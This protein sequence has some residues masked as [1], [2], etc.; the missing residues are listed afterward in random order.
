MR[1]AGADFKEAVVYQHA[2]AGELPP[3]VSEMLRD[4]LLDWI[5]LSSP[6]IARNVA[7]LVSPD[8][9]PRVRFAA[10]SPVTAEAA[11]AG[12]LDVSVV[13]PTHTWPGMLDAVAAH[14]ASTM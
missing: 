10:I 11:L 4:G 6:S 8:L 13:A 9:R 12:G 2:D 7:A 3:P 1:Q 5:C 14:V